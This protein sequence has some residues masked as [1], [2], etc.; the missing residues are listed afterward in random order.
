MNATYAA[1]VG[2]EPSVTREVPVPAGVG[3]TRQTRKRHMLGKG[4]IVPDNA[5][6]VAWLDAS[7]PGWYSVVK[8]DQ[9]RTLVFATTAHAALFKLF[10]T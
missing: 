10:W 2:Q 4:R 1:V 5:E 6:M 7:T 3:V 8:N 9:G